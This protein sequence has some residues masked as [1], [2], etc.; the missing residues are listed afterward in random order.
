MKKKTP[1]PDTALPVEA[2]GFVKRLGQSRGDIGT[3]E[4]WIAKIALTLAARQLMSPG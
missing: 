3:E 2:A 4:Q 1:L